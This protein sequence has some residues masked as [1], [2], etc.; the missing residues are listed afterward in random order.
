MAKY[1]TRAVF[2][3]ELMV[4]ENPKDESTINRIS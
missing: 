2:H 1:V 3:N 4:H